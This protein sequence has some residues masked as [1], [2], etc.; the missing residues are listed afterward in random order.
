MKYMVDE[1]IENLAPILREEGI[2]C[3]T[4]YEW[5]DGKRQKSR[6]IDDAEVRRFLRDRKQKGDEI[7]LITSDRDSWRHVDVDEMPVIYVQNALKDYITRLEK[8]SMPEK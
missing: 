4:I 8:S 2:D 1:M 7:T 6:K 5:I 3:R